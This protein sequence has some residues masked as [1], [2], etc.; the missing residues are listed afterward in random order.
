LSLIPNYRLKDKEKEDLFSVNLK[1]VYF[2]V[3][4]YEVKGVQCIMGAP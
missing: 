4:H 2:S 3:K 1:I